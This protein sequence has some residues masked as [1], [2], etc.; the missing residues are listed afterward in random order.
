MDNANP[1]E[2]ATRRNFRERLPLL[3]GA[4]FLCVI[5]LL[6]IQAAI[7]KE[8]NHDENMYL[9][10]GVLLYQGLLP[11]KDFPYFQMPLSTL[12]YAITLWTS[13]DLLLGARLVN[14]TF[15][16][17]TCLALYFGVLRICANVSQPVRVALASSGVILFVSNPTLLYT[18]GLAWNHD[19]PVFL[20]V[21]GLVL[22]VWSFAHVRITFIL[23]MSGMLFGLAV[24]ARL[25]FA[26]AVV[27]IALAV[28]TVEPTSG[29]DSIMGRVRRCFTYCLGVLVGLLPS[30]FFL[31][32]DPAAF[33]FG[34]MEYHQLNGQFWEQSGYTRAMTFSGKIAYLSDVVSA[35]P[36]NWLLLAGTLL[37]FVLVWRAG[38][39]RTGLLAVYLSAVTA[40]VLLL[41]ALVPS[42]TWLQ[43]F[44]APSVFV[45]FTFVYGVAYL[46][47]T[48]WRRVGYAVLPIVAAI[49]ALSILPR[50]LD[51]AGSLDLDETAPAQ[52]HR[53]ALEIRSAIGGRG[54]VATLA[55]IYAL[56]AGLD[57]YPELAPGPF[58]SRVAGL[59]TQER[60]EDFGVWSGDDLGTALSQRPPEA[61]LVGLEGALEDPLVQFATNQG[62]ESLTLS[63]GLVLWVKGVK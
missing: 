15:T 20:A 57:I 6:L 10:G 55:P 49:S 50:Y 33:W 39:H 7:H 34:N 5:F 56:E 45:V 38:L 2:S 40:A 54:T 16:F 61:V 37:I 29:T 31:L 9:S 26:V 36:F 53:T 8:L 14:T 13:G 60:R 59:L 46:C 11:Y 21:S 30:L 28:L 32:A 43:Y 24:S 52:V 25:S 62:Y 23:L 58:A 1:H 19:L 47:E 18:A 27:P 42:P 48:R 4:A 41:A 51:L 22:L 35:E 44:Y 63:N 17:L 12:V 3:F